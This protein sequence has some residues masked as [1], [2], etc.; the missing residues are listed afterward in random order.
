MPVDAT[1][2]APAFRCRRHRG[3]GSIARAREAAASRPRSSTELAAAAGIAADWWDVS[4]ERHIV[5]ADTKR[6]LLAAMGFRADSTS[7]ARAHLA[8]IGESRGSNDRRGWRRSSSRHGRVAAP[9]DRC[10]LPPELRAGAR[11]FGL[12]AHLYALRRNGDQGIGDFT[13]LAE[14]AAATARAGG[15]IV[16]VN[17]LHALFPE[18][19]ERASPYHP[20]D[21]RFLDP[22]YIDVERV[23]DLAA[24]DEARALLAA[25]RPTH[26]GARG[27]RRRRLRRG[28]GN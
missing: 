26:C 18:D 20:S 24:S 14:I 5:G 15:S 19:R 13:T 8:A 2:V 23:P 16:G 17:P 7:D 27:E 9:P 1:T 28:L 12:A 4:G 25:K 21:R 10:F 22:I 3:A 6:A 11:R